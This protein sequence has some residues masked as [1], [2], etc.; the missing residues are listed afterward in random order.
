MGRSLSAQRRLLAAFC[1]GFF[2][3]IAR[4]LLSSV[5]QTCAGKGWPYDILIINLSG[6]LIL[7]LVTTIA[8][9]TSL[10]GPT[11]RL[12]INVGF[13]GSYTTFSTFALGDVQLFSK[14]QWLP[15]LLYVIFS[16]L[17]GVLLVMLGDV[18]GQSSIRLARCAKQKSTS[19]TPPTFSLQHTTKADHPDIQGDSSLPDLTSEGEFRHPH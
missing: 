13:L 2:G 12:F 16:I 4:Y 1:G 7:A 18:L 10:V 8:E 11:R 14:G 9:A 6:A 17:G 3:A 19:Q 5:I 15:A